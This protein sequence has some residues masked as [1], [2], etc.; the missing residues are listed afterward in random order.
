MIK[1]RAVNFICIVLF[2]LLSSCSSNK[3]YVIKAGLSQNPEEPQVR[4]VELFKEIVEEKTGG[5]IQVRI[6]PN[7]QLGNL[8]DIVEGIQLGT[9]Q[10]TNAAGVMASFVQGLNIFELPFL[11]RN[12][13]HFYAVLDSEIGE[14]LRPAFHRRGF[15][16]LG[17]FDCGVRHIMTVEKP[18][19]SIDDLKGMKIRTMENPAHL[20]TFKIFG[21]NP[22]PLAYGELY[23]ALE[24]KVID[25]AEAANTNYYAKKFYEPASFWA[26]LGWIHLIEYTVMSRYFYERLPKEYK[27][28]IDEAAKIM[29]TKEREWYKENDE[30]M[31]EK[32]KEKGVT[33]TYPEKKPFVRLSRQLYMEWADEVGGMELIE[34]I[35]NFKYEEN[36]K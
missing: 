14:S 27:K 9:V 25:G 28:I 32:L 11:F 30:H 17:Y 5:T 4:A 6:Y 36:R 23:T 20:A 18:V 22:M 12:R 26:Q 10:M 13:D 16:L 34:R 35:I 7:N 31:L 1:F 2:I 33:I 3:T 15:H 19:A 21:A 24:Q 8:R 29:V